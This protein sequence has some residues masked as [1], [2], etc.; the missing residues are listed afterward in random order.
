ME[1]TP[2]AQVIADS[3][4][5]W[6]SD[7]YHNRR[8][9]RLLMVTGPFGTGKTMALKGA[10]RFVR[11]VYMDVWPRF[12]DHPIT[13]IV[14]PWPQ[15]SEDYERGKTGMYDDIIKSDVVFLDDVGAESDRFKSGVKTELLGNLLSDLA[16]RFVLITSNI[17]PR[18]WREKW[19]GRVEDRLNR[20][21]ALCDLWQIGATSYAQR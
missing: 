15:F 4:Q 2:A 3:V 9:H 13:P 18:H 14:V 11:G 21:A 5:A 1:A 12:W 19:G 20:N 16:P 10:A 6:C 7:V 17:E 8:D